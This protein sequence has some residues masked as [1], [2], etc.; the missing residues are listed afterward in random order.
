MCRAPSLTVFSNLLLFPSTQSFG[1]TSKEELENVHL[2]NPQRVFSLLF[3]RVTS[4][5]KRTPPLSLLP[6]RLL[7]FCHFSDSASTVKRSTK[8]CGCFILARSRRP[9]RHPPNLFPAFAKPLPR[10]TTKGT[11]ISLH[12]SFLPPFFT[13]FLYSG[14]SVRRGL[15]SCSPRSQALWSSVA[16]DFGVPPPPFPRLVNAPERSVRR[17]SSF[18]SCPLFRYLTFSH[19]HSLSDLLSL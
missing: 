18:Q 16:P 15:M 11:F 2:A 10:K 14:R 17:E 4:E 12:P 8:M 3:H 5:I 13:N 9:L 19:S 7:F 6:G 1:P